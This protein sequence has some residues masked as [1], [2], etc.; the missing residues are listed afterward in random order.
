M[1]AIRPPR[2]PSEHPAKRISSKPPETAPPVTA[3]LAVKEGLRM[4]ISKRYAKAA[5]ALRQAIEMD[6]LPE[7]RVWL[8][9]CEARRH[10]DAGDPDET[11]NGDPPCDPLP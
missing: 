3:E 9:V 1:N 4:L 8:E 6:D 11:A 5:E 2:P 10:R 7:T